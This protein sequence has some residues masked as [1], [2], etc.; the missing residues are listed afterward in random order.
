MRKVV[1]LILMFFITNV[2]VASFLQGDPCSTYPTPPATGICSPSVL[3]NDKASK[4]FR[5]EAWDTLNGTYS[6]IHNKLKDVK[7]E[8]KATLTYFQNSNEDLDS[9]IALLK[10]NLLKEKEILFLLKQ[11]NEIQS[12]RNSAI[13]TGE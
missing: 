7:N 8:Y 3:M 1:A 2:A 4:Q 6:Q 13:T 5:E 9:E 11:F 12:V 10:D